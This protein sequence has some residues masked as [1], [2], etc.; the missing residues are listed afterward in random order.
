VKRFY[1]KENGY[2]FEKTQRRMGDE[3]EET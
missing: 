1:E 3:K 2:A